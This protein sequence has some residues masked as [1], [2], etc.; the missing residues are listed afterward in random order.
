GKESC[1]DIEYWSKLL[2]KEH[3]PKKL[4]DAWKTWHDAV[5]HAEGPLFAKYVELANAGA[6]GIGFG[7]VSQRWK[8]G[9]DMPPAQFEAEVDRLGGKVKPLYDQLHCY[10]RR[11]LNKEYGDKVVSKTG[12]I[13]AHLFGNMW[14]QDWSYLYPELEPYKGVAAIDVTP[15]LAKSYD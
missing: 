7:D 8:A 13:P 10:A 4:V 6:R 15:V 12:P 3:N 2:Q 14:S 9:Y 11:Q 1:K 5:G